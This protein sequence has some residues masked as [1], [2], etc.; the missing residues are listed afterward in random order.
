M[1]LASHISIH[2]IVIKQAPMTIPNLALS[3]L[4]DENGVPTVFP[5]IRKP[6]TIAD[7]SG[8]IQT[9]DFGLISVG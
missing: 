7:W 6:A 2:P 8:L 1:S 9:G 3:R 5:I 4:I